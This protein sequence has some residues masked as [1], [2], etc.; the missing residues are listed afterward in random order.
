VRLFDQKLKIIEIKESLA[1][2]D[3]V[4]LEFKSLTDFYTYSGYREG[5]NGTWYTFDV[6]P[7]YGHYIADPQTETLVLSS[8]CLL[9]QITLYAIPSA[10]IK[11]TYGIEGD[12]TR[13]TLNFISAFSWNETHFVR[14]ILGQNEEDIQV[15][16]QD[17]PTNT[18]GHAVLN[19]NFYG[20]ATSFPDD[21]FSLQIPSM[22]PL[23]KI[24]MAAPASINSVQVADC[25]ERGGGVPIDYPLQAFNT[26]ASGLDYLRGFLD[27]G[28]WS[29][30]V[31]NEGGVV[32]IHLNSEVLNTQT[33]DQIQE[34]VDSHMLPGV[35][36]EIIYED[37]V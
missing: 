20:E 14:H 35:S 7:E 9:Q 12:N 26:N 27:L 30:A 10:Y 3:Q 2:S 29:G 4:E 15:R 31:V 25:R 24:V 22:M 23:G 17:G 1:P 36:A 13:I 33:A 16:Q 19:R 5:L 8:D 37:G 18:W 6:N 28:N 11:I 34:L 21:I 32:E